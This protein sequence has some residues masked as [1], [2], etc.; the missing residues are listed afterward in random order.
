MVKEVLVSGKLTYRDVLEYMFYHNY[1]R[2]GGALTGVAG[3]VSLL[4][5]PWFLYQRDWVVG[6]LLTFIALA[7]GV[8]TP[9]FFYGR[10]RRKMRTNPVFKNK[11]TYRF[12]SDMLRVQLY[13]G[14]TDILWQ[15][16]HCFRFTRNLVLVYLKGNNALI[17][18]VRHFAC[19][20]DLVLVKE[21][22][23]RNHLA[24]PKHRRLEVE[25][26]DEEV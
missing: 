13:T 16:I 3:I 25:I 7:Y 11:M 15:D 1:T 19:D 23:E 17:I 21:F 18:P 2:L 26:H 12:T 4:A 8:L 5:A 9:L 24:I 14:D 6:G 22:V 10:S 20:D